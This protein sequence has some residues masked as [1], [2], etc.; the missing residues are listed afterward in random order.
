MFARRPISRVS[1]HQHHL[2][3]QRAI[4]D[5]EPHAVEPGVH[6]PQT[7]LS[8]YELTSAIGRGCDLPTQ[9]P[10]A[11]LIAGRKQHDSAS[12]RAAVAPE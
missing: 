6:P 8:R 1:R 11:R 9:L 5:L 2:L 10:P 12:F 4:G 3:I 7:R